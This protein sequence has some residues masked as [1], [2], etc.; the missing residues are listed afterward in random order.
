MREPPMLNIIIF[1]TG[2]A[3]R[4]IKDGIDYSKVTIKAFADNNSALWGQTYEGSPVI[5]PKHVVDIEF[6]H[7]IIASTYYKEITGQLTGYGVPENKIIPWFKKRMGNDLSLYN[8]IFKSEYLMQRQLELL[9]EKVDS[10]LKQMQTANI[11]LAAKLNADRLANLSPD[12]GLS[13]FEYKV[14]SQWGEDGIIQYLIHNTAIENQVFVEFGVE[15]YTEANTRFLLVNN[16]WSG[17]VIDGS[18]ENIDYVKNDDI[19]WKHQLTAACSFITKDNINDLILN[20]GISGDIGLLSVDIDGNDYWVWEAINVVNPRIVV[21][22]YNSVFGD[23]FEVTVP[24]SSDF[25]RRKAHYSCLYYGASLAA[26]CGLAEKKGYVFVGCNSAGNNAFFIRSDLETDCK[27]LT[28]QEGFVSSKFRESRNERGEPTFL[29][30]KEKLQAIKE[31]YVYDLSSKTEIKIED[32][33]RLGSD[34]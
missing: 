33:F 3:Y 10:E 26:L 4:K 12:K 34:Y 24:Y 18:E 16:N 21:A 7:V 22:E 25:Q 29:N 6:D 23:T 32:L 17:L 1:G 5:E 19:Y 28:P 15:N 14:Y 2:S 13:V 11:M 9:Q 20:A 31:K 27:K 30:G 8:H